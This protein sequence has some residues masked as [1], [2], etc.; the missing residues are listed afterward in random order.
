MA[1]RVTLNTPSVMNADKLWEEPRREKRK[2]KL[3]VD[4]ENKA[5]KKYSIPSEAR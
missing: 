4:K 5:I 1:D 3:I 2:K